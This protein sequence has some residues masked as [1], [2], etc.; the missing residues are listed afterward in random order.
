[1]PRV[2][3]ILPVRNGENFLRETIASLCGQSFG[4]FELIICDNAS[5][6]RTGEIAGAAAARDS[7]IVY[8]RHASD[9]GAARN[10]NFGFAQARG[11]FVK[12]CA[13]DDLLSPDYV[14]GCVGALARNPGAVLAY[15][16][17]RG[18]DAQ[19]LP[20]GADLRLPDYF[21]P[22]PE[23]RF[24]M[25]MGILNDA[26][27]FGLWRA[28]ALW[29]SGLHRPFYGSDRAL[30]AEMALA[31]TFVHV[32]EIVF[33]NRDHAQ[34]SVHIADKRRRASWQSTDGANRLGL[35]HWMLLGT[36][37]AIAWEHRRTSRL[38]A[39]LGHLARAA[40]R[41]QQI[42]RYGLELVGVAAPSLRHRLR[43]GGWAMVR[44]I[45]ALVRPRAP[46]PVEPPPARSVERTPASGLVD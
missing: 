8:H 25:V 16:S 18:I 19:G 29:R 30:L 26:L 40:L 11:E 1:M 35:E 21:H 5:D 17:G 31:G 24:A 22:S 12:W 2:S 37:I 42:C 39:T 13:H 3:L 38:P 20:T 46:L 10:Y 28:D 9:V 36:L 7:R 41:P 34:R 43:A 15:G 14:A 4:D 23:R 44:S 32:P 33:Y 6:D 27:I 45:R